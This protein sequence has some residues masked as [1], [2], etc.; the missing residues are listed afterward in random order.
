MWYFF[1]LKSFLSL[2]AFREKNLTT[3]DEMIDKMESE[4]DA[5]QIK[6]TKI[7]EWEINVIL[8]CVDHTEWSRN[9]VFWDE[10][11]G[12]GRG[13]KLTAKYSS[14]CRNQSAMW[15]DSNLDKGDYSLWTNKQKLA[16]RGF[17]VF[18]RISIAEN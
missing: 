1:T 17:P 2:S 13:W 18:Q 7:K 9:V 5:E 8:N 14:A 4:L 16:H 11:G 3:F 12:L 15:T 6:E 10:K